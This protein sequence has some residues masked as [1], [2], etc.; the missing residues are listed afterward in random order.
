MAQPDA[1]ALDAWLDLSR[2]N[3]H[4]QRST[5]PNA[6]TGKETETVEWITQRPPGWIVPIP[7]G[8]GAL[9][10][11]HPPGTVANARDAT[12]PF[13]FVESVYSMGQ[14]ISPHRLRDASELLWYPQHDPASGL[15]RCRND[16]LPP[17]VAP[18]ALAT[19]APRN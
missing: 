19:P 2:L 17:I 1:T 10:E 6:S 11:L 16:F 7:V 8:Y 3:H 15:Y 5:V 4:A 9:S 13:R 12:T 14:W 18:Q